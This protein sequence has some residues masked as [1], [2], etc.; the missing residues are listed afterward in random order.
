MIAH[1]KRYLD[2]TGWCWYI[3][4]SDGTVSVGTVVNEEKQIQKRKALREKAPD[5]TMKDFY[6]TQV[7][8]AP[9]IE[10]LLRNATLVSSAIKSASDYS[11]SATQKSGPHFRLVGDAAG[12][13]NSL[14][15][16]I[17]YI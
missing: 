14:A 10:K 16:Y 17:K 6:M 11:Y 3:P 7:K 1:G 13:L 8:L 9:M 2:E 5:S 12:K 15:T 4:L